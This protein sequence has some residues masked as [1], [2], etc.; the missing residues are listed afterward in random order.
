MRILIASVLV[1]FGSSSAAAEPKTAYFADGYHGGVYGHYPPG[2][3]GFIVEQLKANPNWKINLEIEPDTWDVA[4]VSELGA[5]RALKAILEDRSDAGRIEI[6]NPTYAQSYLFQASGESVI[7]QFDLGIRKTREHFPNVV[8]K[9]YSSEEPCF[10]SCLPAVLRSFGFKYAVLKN[11]DTCWGGYTTARGGELANWIGPDGSSILAVPRYACEALQ[12]GSCWQTIAFRNSAQYIEA[13]FGQGIEHPVGMCLQ[14]AG[15]RGG[16]WLGRAGKDQHAPS[17]YITWR[18]YIVNVTPARADS[19]WRFTQEDVKPGLMWGAQVLQRIAR[20]SRE[21]EHRLLAAEKLAS[22]AFVW[23]GRPPGTAS[24]D[25]AWRNVLLTQHHDCW[26]VPYNG[27]LGNTWADQVRRWTNFSNAVSDLSLQRSLDALLDGGA[28]RGRRFV[29]LFNPTAAILDAVAPVPIP[30]TGVPKRT[31]ALD[32]DGHR[33]PTQVVASDTPGRSQLL[34]RATVPPL[35][36]ATVELRDDAGATEAG[37]TAAVDSGGVVMES[38]LYRIELDPARGGT[39]RS[40]LVKSLGG[41][42]FV[43]T[44]HER[45]FNELR[46][47]FYDQGGF[48]SSADRPAKVRIVESG[49]LRGTAE[50]AGTIAGHPFMQRVSITQASPLIDCSIRIDWRGNPHIGESAEKDGSRNRRRPAYDNRYKLLALF[51]TR[52]SGQRIAKSAPFDVCESTLGDTF[53]GSWEDIKNNVIL[54]WVDVGDANG[55][56]GLALFSDHTTSYAHGPNFPLGLTLQ[57]SGK[58][59]WGR[60]YRIEGPT[61]VRYALMPHRGRWDKAGIPA[62]SAS[63]QEPVL[64]AAS[65]ARERRGRS[66]IEPRG[67]GWLVPAIFERDAALHVRLFNASG[68]DTP[69]DLVVGFEAGKIELVELDGRVI[70]DL[71]AVVDDKGRRTIHLRIPRFG[72]RTLRFREINTPPPE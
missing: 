71:K 29:R 5:Y 16:P 45:R 13:C 49:P 3:T 1:C 52:L 60:D 25:E 72:I 36:Y 22:I 48:H 26:I 54:D 33:F 66:L 61:E 40:L 64:G 42:E 28:A 53:F 8:L 10:T 50:I 4:R 6:V 27:R 11:P 47:H 20:Q 17:K 15:W 68:D 56:H 2:Y 57:Y 23:A 69:G 31:I 41:R 35:G 37:V 67:S 62:V 7:R 12:P 14:D 46:G 63:W 65:H 32:A 44:A 30:G 58:G 51:P 43:D 18:D 34:V 59:L 21:S 55:D 70:E 39:F 9:T 24:F 38:D 19:D